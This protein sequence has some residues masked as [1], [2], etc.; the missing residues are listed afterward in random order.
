MTRAKYVIAGLLTLPFL[1]ACNTVQGVGKDVQA[2]GQGV[3]NAA[4]YVERE[5]FGPQTQRSDSARISYR[6]ASIRVGPACD[7]E[8]ELAGGANLPAC[9]KRIVRPTSTRQ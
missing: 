8:T 7:P 9:N 3:S 6:T 4:N 1:A 5:M 2:V